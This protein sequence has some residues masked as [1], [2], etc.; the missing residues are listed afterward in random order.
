MNNTTLTDDKFVTFSL[1]VP[2]LES[3]V[4]FYRVTNEIGDQLDNRHSL[5]IIDWLRNFIAKHDERVGRGG[6][7]CPFIPQ[8]LVQGTI[9]V[10]V[11]DFVKLNSSLSEFLEFLQQARS[12]FLNL[13]TSHF[14]KMLSFL[15]VFPHLNEEVAVELI[16]TAQN[17]LKMDFLEHGLMLGE[18]FPRNNV[19]SLRN[20]AF[21]PFRSPV[22]MMG[23]RHMIE[24]DVAFFEL[25]GKTAPKN[26]VQYL[27]TYVKFFAEDERYRSGVIRAKASIE[28]L[29]GKEGAKN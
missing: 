24:E 17:H 16:L 11:L 2:K 19:P 8:A 29:S 4:N 13:S 14:G 10:G 5:E 28:R 26:A 18:F 12:T 7:V 3:N 20:E 9:W 1:S 15:M 6:T 21:F 27:K 22:P 23:I 25:A